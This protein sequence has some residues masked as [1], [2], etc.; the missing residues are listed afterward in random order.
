M[1]ISNTVLAILIIA[2]VMIVSEFV[3]IWSASL[4]STSTS[5]VQ[6]GAQLTCGTAGIQLSGVSFCNNFLTG[7]ITNT[8]SIALSNV[9]MSLLYSNTSSETIYLSSNGNSVTGLPNCCSSLVMQPAD[10]YNF[11]FSIGGSNYASLLVTS[12]CPAPQGSAQTI[13][14]SS[15]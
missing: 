10:S 3:N 6:G 7:A 9:T 11:N 13:D 12:N 5:N 15:C 1:R 8:G 4:P 2:V 14:I